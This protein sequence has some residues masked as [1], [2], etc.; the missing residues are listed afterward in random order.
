[1]TTN[2]A[3]R[4]DLRM[5][6]VRQ[7]GSGHGRG[8]PGNVEIAFLRPLARAPSGAAVGRVIDVTPEIIELLEVLF[9]PAHAEHTGEGLLSH[10][11]SLTTQRDNT[12]QNHP[13]TLA[14][15]RRGVRGARPEPPQAMVLQQTLHLRILLFA[16]RRSLHFW[17]SILYR[18]P[19]RR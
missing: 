18:L 3:I 4:T 9:Y 7:P 10:S 1:M 8:D 19:H 14:I 17:R 2:D 13:H 15:R 16:G 11:S 6:N 5:S 12:R